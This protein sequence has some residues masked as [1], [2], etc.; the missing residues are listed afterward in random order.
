VLPCLA[1]TRRGGVV[2]VPGLGLLSMAT[3]LSTVI[4]G[5]DLLRRATD[6]PVVVGLGLL[7][8]VEPRRRSSSSDEGKR[9]CGM[10]TV[11]EVVSKWSLE[12]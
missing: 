3:G 5:R 12:D 11:N 10:M 2:V 7:V 8:R 6:L 9:V 1:S 4:S